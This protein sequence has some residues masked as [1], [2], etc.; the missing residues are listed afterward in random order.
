MPNIISTKNVGGV[1]AGNIMRYRA[2]HEY[3]VEFSGTSTGFGND[4]DQ[5]A[6]HLNG[7]PDETPAQVILTAIELPTCTASGL[8]VTS[9]VGTY[10]VADLTTVVA[11]PDDTKFVKIS[12]AID[13]TTGVL[14]IIAFEKTTESYGNPPAGK[15]VCCDLKEWSVPAL[16]TVLTL[17]TDFIE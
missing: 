4:S 14:E 12:V 16:G 9:N 5:I 2:K 13:D 3:P 8:V 6:I 1:T 10:I 15:T 17:V 7:A 11:D